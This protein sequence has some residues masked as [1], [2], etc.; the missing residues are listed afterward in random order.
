MKKLYALRDNE[1][2][3]YVQIEVDKDIWE[4]LDKLTYKFLYN[5]NWM[6]DDHYR[7]EIRNNDFFSYDKG[8]IYLGIVMCNNRAHIIVLGSKINS[9]LKKFLFERYSF[10]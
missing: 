7:G 8:G 10:E 1:S 2:E 3:F 5:D 9:E 4:L 6:I